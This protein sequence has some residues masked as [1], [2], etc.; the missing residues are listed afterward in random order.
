MSLGVVEA[1]IGLLRLV[2]RLGAAAVL[3]LIEAAVADHKINH[4]KGRLHGLG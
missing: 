2:A 1:A 3:H 4:V